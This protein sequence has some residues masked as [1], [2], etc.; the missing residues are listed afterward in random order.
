MA[1]YLNEAAA[2]ADGFLFS[3][4]SDQRQ[5]I[6]T[7]DDRVIGVAHYTLFD[8]DTE[9]PG[10]DFDHTEVDP[11]FRG[12][13]LSGILARKALSDGIVTGREVKASCW[14]IEGYIAKHPEL[15]EH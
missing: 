12:T 14:F 10:I 1:R 9:H 15:I 5:F 7:K 13:G 2:E 11:E 4:E 3:H 8:D 6:I